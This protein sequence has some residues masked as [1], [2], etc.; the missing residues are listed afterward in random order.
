PA[1]PAKISPRSDNDS[2]TA[3]GGRPVFGNKGHSPTAPAPTTPSLFDTP[4]GETKRAPEKDESTGVSAVVEQ[5]EPASRVSAAD[6][7]PTAQRTSA[8]TSPVPGAPGVVEPGSS[9]DPVEEICDICKC[10]ILPPQE[11]HPL[12]PVPAHASATDCESA[13]RQVR[14]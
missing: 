6:E 11:R 4:A 9:S 3:P 7:E 5:S 13:R 12:M 1:Q 14:K 8:I 2:K 10:P